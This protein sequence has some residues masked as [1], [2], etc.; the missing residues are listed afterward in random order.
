MQKKTLLN[1]AFVLVFAG[2]ALLGSKHVGAQSKLPVFAKGSYFKECNIYIVHDP[3]T[4]LIGKIYFDG[5]KKSETGIKSDINFICAG[6]MG[7]REFESSS[8]FI[9]W[10]NPSY[11]CGGW[12]C[13]FW[14]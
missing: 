6:E 11:G 12:G 5:L 1:I 2:C 14:P 3:E 4:G 8:E 13:S 9:A 7:C 10:K